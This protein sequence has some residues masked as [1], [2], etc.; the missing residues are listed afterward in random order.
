MAMR[1]AAAR[2]GLGNRMRRRWLRQA[3]VIAAGVAAVA[4]PLAGGWY[5]LMVRPERTLWEPGDTTRDELRLACHRVLRWG[6]ERHDVFAFLADVGDESS[7]PLLLD[8]LDEFAADPH[9]GGGCCREGCVQA[10]VALTNQR[11]GDLPA[12]WRAWYAQH[13]RETRW[14]WSLAGFQTLGLPVTDPPDEA[15][16]AALLRFREQGRG[17]ARRAI[18]YVFD[19]LPPGAR[20]RFLAVSLA[21]ADM[22]L[23][24][25]C[26]TE[27]QRVGSDADR[28]RLDALTAAPDPAVAERALTA[29]NQAVR[30]AVRRDGA[31]SSFAGKVLWH[32]QVSPFRLQRTALAD[33]LQTLFFHA[34]EDLSGKHAELGAFDLVTRRVRWRVALPRDSSYVCARGPRV[35]LTRRDRG[36]YPGLL[37]C[38]L[39]AATGRELWQRSVGGRGA[40][41]R[42]ERLLLYGPAIQVGPAPGTAAFGPGILAL[43]LADGTDAF[44]LATEAPVVAAVAAGD[45]AAIATA[46]PPTSEDPTPRRY[47]V[48]R[49][50]GAGTVLWRR[51]GAGDV[52]ALAG[53]AQGVAVLTTVANRVRLTLFAGAEGLPTELYEGPRHSDGPARCRLL[54]AP[55]VVIVQE[56]KRTLAVDR[57][58][59]ARCWSVTHW[60]DRPAQVIGDALLTKGEDGL[61]EVRDLTSGQVLRVYSELWWLDDMQW[62]TGP[63]LLAVATEPRH[64][65]GKDE[66][67]LLD[68]EIP[69]P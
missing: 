20:D 26:I 33:D 47:A 63:R 35:C 1:A 62:H 51:D 3:A 57:R 11:L 50:A 30:V 10:L 7:V 61:P 28:R 22:T 43:H 45:H 17:R 6:S 15:L 54:L 58:T 25:G 5:W 67:W 39:D 34:V 55:A 19:H 14:Q 59:G 9:R 46:H 18:E 27:M 65:Q 52:A 24:R 41:L 40:L 13:G 8:A 23:L 21:D 44:A 48:R 64:G 66:L 4:L 42:G 49:I 38:A 60:I 37:L 36:L 29:Y 53:D 68:P 12:P 31:A 56:E 69:A 2:Y 32:G 16:L